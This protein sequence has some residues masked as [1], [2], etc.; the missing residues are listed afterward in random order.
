MGV[1]STPVCY[2]GETEAQ[3]DTGDLPK[4]TRE[5]EG[6]EDSNPGLTL[7]PVLFGVQ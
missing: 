6:T 4:V 2:G 1:I 3:R 5:S 7:G